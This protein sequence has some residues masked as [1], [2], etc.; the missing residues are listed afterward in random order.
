MHIA[1][2]SVYSNCTDGQVRLF[3]GAT[4][5]EGTVEICLNNAWGTIS[6]SY[7]GYREAQTVCN[8]LGF[9]SPGIWDST[10]TWLTLYNY[11]CIFLLQCTFR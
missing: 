11:R 6:D 9:T 7:W 5:Y 3:G 4:Q 8:S 10:H 1:H 2:G